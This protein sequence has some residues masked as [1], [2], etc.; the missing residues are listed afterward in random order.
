MTFGRGESNRNY[1]HGLAKTP[2]HNAWRFMRARC[3]NPNR[4]E[5]PNYGG[6]GIKVCERWQTFENFLA[7]MGEMP[8]GLTLDR[9][10]NDGNYEP[11]NCRW[12]T[13]R[14]QMQ[15]KRSNVLLEFM[16]QRKTARQW[17]ETLGLPYR[18]IRTR[19]SR[20]WTVERALTA[21]KQY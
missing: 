1:R 15:N 11:E 20:G 17:S 19:I 2:T 3:E 7:D 16:G 14:E 12:A 8:E 10:N 13:Y 4:P 9:I 5:Y 18:T 6:R 21:P